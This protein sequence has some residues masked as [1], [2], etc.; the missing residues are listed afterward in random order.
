MLLQ[1]STNNAKYTSFDDKWYSFCALYM[2]KRDLE[3]WSVQEKKLHKLSVF[4]TKQSHYQYKLQHVVKPWKIYKNLQYGRL[5]EEKLNNFLI[6]CLLFEF[7][8][9]L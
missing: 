6:S 7:S 9:K 8:L 2:Q 4:I 1:F 3:L 5:S